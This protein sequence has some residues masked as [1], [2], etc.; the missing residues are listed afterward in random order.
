M[1]SPNLDRFHFA[2]KAPMPPA[3]FSLGAHSRLRL[4][5]LRKWWLW[6]PRIF[7][8]AVCYCHL[9]VGQQSASVLF[10]AAAERFPC[11]A[12]CSVRDC[13]SVL[14]HDHLSPAKAIR[15]IRFC[16]QGERAA[17]RGCKLML[18]Q[19]SNCDLSLDDLNRE[20]PTREIYHLVPPGSCRA[21]RFAPCRRGDRPI[22]VTR[23]R[24]A[25]RGGSSCRSAQVAGLLRRHAAALSKRGPM[26]LVGRKGGAYSAMKNS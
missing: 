4:R 22:L 25:A 19:L 8:A 6:P 21:V 16:L 24:D 11:S 15:H 18:H 14:R 7:S 3:E 20:F 12:K 2:P 9:A 26:P 23:R 17:I 10:E 5:L 1:P 13:R